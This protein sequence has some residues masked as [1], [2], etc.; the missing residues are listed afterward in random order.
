MGH[1]AISTRMVR[2]IVEARFADTG[3]GIPTEHLGRI[4]DTYF[5]S[6]P[7]R[8]GTGVGLA[9]SLRTVERHQGSISVDSEVGIWTTVV[10]RPPAHPSEDVTTQRPS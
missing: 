2:G 1:L 6:K 4:F 5:T 3:I 8:K 10:V 7:E 9:S